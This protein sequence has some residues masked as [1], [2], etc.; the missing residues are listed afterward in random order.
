MLELTIS[1]CRNNQDVFDLKYLAI[2][3]NDLLQLGFEGK[4][5]GKILN[6]LLDLVMQDK[7]KNKRNSLLEAIADYK[8]SESD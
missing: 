5:I 4:Q 6:E 2:N 1:D 3:G 7:V 8:L